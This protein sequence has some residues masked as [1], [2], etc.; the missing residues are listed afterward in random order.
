MRFFAT[1]DGRVGFQGVPAVF[2]ELLRQIPLW[3]GDCG[4]DVEARFYPA[5]S[6]ESGEESLCDDWKAHVEPE[7]H[8]LFQS[9]RQRV[10]ADLRGLKEEDGE[11]QLEFPVGHMDA[12]LSALNQARLALAERFRF[13][14]RELSA[15]GPKEIASERDLA[16]LQIDF[17]GQVQGW[18]LEIEDDTP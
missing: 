10:E 1:S 13:G 4:E 5:P 16:L 6:R 11:F 12:W 8:E 17:Y 18:L 2:A 15:S 3:G 7:L 14:E 9:S